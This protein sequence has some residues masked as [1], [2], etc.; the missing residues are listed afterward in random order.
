MVLAG[1]YP[2]PSPSK[3]SKS[4]VSFAT[5]FG[6]AAAAAGPIRGTIVFSSDVEELQ[7]YL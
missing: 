4:N 5:P 6:N 3:P 2:Q 1:R 7:N